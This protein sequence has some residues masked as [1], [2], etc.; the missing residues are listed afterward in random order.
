MVHLAPDSESVFSDLFEAELDYV[1]HTL[2]RLGISDEDLEDVAQEVFVQVHR[3]FAEFDPG[4]PAR[5]WLVA[6]AYR[7]ASN[8]RRAMRRRNESVAD[9][10]VAELG[11]D[12]GRTQTGELDQKRLV[13][14]VLDQMSAERSVV[15]LMFDVD[16]HSAPEIAAAL[17]LPLNTVYS[18][19]R[20]ARRD[21]RSLG[22]ALF[23]VES[24]DDE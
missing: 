18:R 5:P 3:R 11:G 12:D 24:P 22:A 20:L 16:G 6:F 9:S 13:Q 23:S 8:H 4:R 10:E 19:I 21:F 15:L 17:D 7:T 1:L 14:R 2:R